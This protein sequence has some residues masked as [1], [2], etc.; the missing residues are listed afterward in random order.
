MNRKS[1]YTYTVIDLKA[2]DEYMKKRR[3]VLEA[4]ASECS[5]KMVHTS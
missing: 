1:V 4:R 5:R 2:Y 3:Y